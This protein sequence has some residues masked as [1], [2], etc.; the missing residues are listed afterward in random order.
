MGAE[1]TRLALRQATPWLATSHSLAQN[2]SE[3]R[4]LLGILRPLVTSHKIPD[5]CDFAFRDR[6]L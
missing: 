6:W 2:K 3:S 5:I 4:L 1:R